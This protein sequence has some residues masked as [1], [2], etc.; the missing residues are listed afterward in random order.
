[1]IGV[2][3]LLAELPDA[4]GDLGFGTQDISRQLH[5]GAFSRTRMRLVLSVTLKRSSISWSTTQAIRSPERTRGI[6]PR[7]STGTLRSIRNDLT[8]SE[9]R[10]VGKGWVA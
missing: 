5:R 1:G 2:G 10:R 6:R 7:S 8:R 4:L 9:E 3:D